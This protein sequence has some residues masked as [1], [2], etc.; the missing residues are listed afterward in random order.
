MLVG[1]G[2]QTFLAFISCKVFYAALMFMSE[3]HPVNY[4]LFMAMSMTPTASGGIGPMIKSV[5]VNCNLKSRVM[6]LW[7]LGTTVYIALSP[8]F[9]DALS[10]Y[11]AIQVTMVCLSSSTYVSECVP[12]SKVYLLHRHSVSLL[13]RTQQRYPRDAS[14]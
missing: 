13:P 4:E 3:R 6:L 2:I 11:R 10:G 7:L 12:L 14:R 9:I 1:R 8:T 5:I